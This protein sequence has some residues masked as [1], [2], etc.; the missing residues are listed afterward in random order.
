MNN[1][2]LI[3]SLSSFILGE[4]DKKVPGYGNNPNQPDI[5]Q[6]LDIWIFTLAN[7]LIIQP[8]RRVKN[9]T[10]DVLKVALDPET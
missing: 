6:R 4:L 10:L 7:Y 9:R 5:F 2:T 8:F 1:K 3:F